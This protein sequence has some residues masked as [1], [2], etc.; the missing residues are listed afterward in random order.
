MRLKFD[1]TLWNK[2]SQKAEPSR[3]ERGIEQVPI[4][5][6]ERLFRTP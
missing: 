1:Y 4:K 6:N 2:G 3:N 5:G